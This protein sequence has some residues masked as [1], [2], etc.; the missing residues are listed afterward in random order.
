VVQ[1]V[2]AEEAKA[3]EARA[4]EA[5]PLAEKAA[6][7]VPMEAKAAEAV[8]VE[9]KAA[10]KAMR[11]VGPLPPA[12]PLGAAAVTSL[13]SKKHRIPLD[14]YSTF[15]ETCTTKNPQHATAFTTNT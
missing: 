6:E 13:P 4:A 15:H 5:D 7:A 11:E 10:D 12:T 8:P 1:V 2:R 3:V 14:S 9:A